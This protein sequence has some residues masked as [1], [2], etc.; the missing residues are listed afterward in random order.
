MWDTDHAR[1]VV[2]DESRRRNLANVKSHLETRGGTM[3]ASGGIWR[4]HLEVPGEIRGHLQASEVPGGIWRHLGASGGIGKL[5]KASGS[6]WRHLETSGNIW[7]H[8]ETSRTSGAIWRHLE[9]S[10]DIWRHLEAPRA[11][12]KHPSAPGCI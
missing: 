6:L 7:K 3:G 1:G 4:R 12:W 2:Q 10:G 5:L 11:F 9:P 8:L